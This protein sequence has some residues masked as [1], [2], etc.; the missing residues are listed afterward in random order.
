MERI[1]SS[2]CRART[3]SCSC[4]VGVLGCRFA[5]R[6]LFP[7]PGKG[8]V[9]PELVISSFLVDRLRLIK[10]LEHERCRPEICTKRMASVRGGAPRTS[11]GIIQSARLWFRAQM[12]SRMFRQQRC[13]LCLH[14]RRRAV[15][16][17]G[18]L[19]AMEV[20]LGLQILIEVS[21]ICPTVEGRV[22]SC[23]KS[24]GQKFVHQRGSGSSE[25]CLSAI[26]MEAW[27]RVPVAPRAIG[28]R[29]RLSSYRTPKNLPV[30]LQH[31]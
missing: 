19:V 13:P 17:P 5:I 26:W 14:L 6:D 28:L 11:T 25:K 20:L 10:C 9:L 24:S 22:H 4:V 15:A 18:N 21:S 29:A 31:R 8:R 30:V 16:D 23:L 7:L 3:S 1:D 2:G 12:A 27:G